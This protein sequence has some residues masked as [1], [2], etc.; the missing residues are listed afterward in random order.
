MAPEPQTDP[1]DEN[2]VEDL[3][4]PSDRDLD[5][6]ST[7]WTQLHNPASFALRYTSALSDYLSNLL[8]DPDRAEE[9]LQEVLLKMMNQGFANARPERGRFRDYLKVATRNQALAFLR[10]E[11]RRK[12]VAS[13]HL[14]SLPEHDSPSTDQHWLDSW[15]NCVVEKA[16]RAL[17]RHEHQAPQSLVYTALK[18]TFEQPDTDSEELA[19]LASNL[20]N[21]A[22]S[23]EAF[24]KQRSR[25]RKLFAR[26][27]IA[28]VAAT[29]DPPTPEEIDEE[30]CLLGLKVYVQDVWPVVPT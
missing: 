6:I 4:A 18:L 20:V 29:V 14:E 5:Q 11:H 2:D 1:A 17:E 13:D 23:A 26:L 21:R 25:A 7:R 16:W 9:V 22:V 3:E 27:L 24:R 12:T 10:R 19:K 15:R 30:L 28:E 8:G